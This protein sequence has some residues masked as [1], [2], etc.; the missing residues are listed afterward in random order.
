MVGWLG[1]SSRAGR[2]PGV[3]R[4]WR[5]G[6]TRVNLQSRGKSQAVPTP[7]KLLLLFLFAGSL[8]SAREHSFS[9]YESLP[10]LK[11][12]AQPAAPSLPEAELQPS[13][14]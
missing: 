4:R 1:Y 10:V 2:L 12:P 3:L 9:P 5:G 14:N 13:Q 6:D 7:L 8:P 11:E